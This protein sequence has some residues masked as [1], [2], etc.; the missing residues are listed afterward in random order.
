[1]PFDI[2]AEKNIGGD[3]GSARSAEVPRFSVVISK[4]RGT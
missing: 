1:L 2:N 4:R 3:I